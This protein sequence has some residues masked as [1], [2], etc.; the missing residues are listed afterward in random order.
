MRLYLILFL[1]ASGTTALAQT[2][3]SSDYRPKKRKVQELEEVTIKRER[4]RYTTSRTSSSLRM[5]S[6]IQEIPQNIQVVTK[7]MLKDQQVVSMSD[8]LIRNVSGLVR[9][10]HWGD[11]YTNITARGAQVQAFR[12]GFNVVN[13][14]WGPLTED[15]SFVENIEFVKGP[16]GFM[17]S[18]GDP[19][20]LY[21]VVTKKPTG[22]T[23]SEVDLTMGSFGLYRAALDLEGKLS[24]DGNLLYRL[25]VAAQNKKSFRPN[26]YN[27]RYTIAPVVSYQL[28]KKT[29]LTLEYTYQR[30]NMSNVGS[31]YV[32]DPRGFG[33]QPVDYTMLPAGLPG[34]KINDHSMYLNIQHEINDNWK[35]TAQAARFIY[36][37]EGASA[38]PGVVNPDGTVIRN[39]GIWDAKSN[40]TLAQAFVNGDA[41]TGSIHHKI[42]GGL[43]VGSKE[44]FADWSQ[45][46][47]LDDT[48]HYFNIFDPNA[49]VNNVSNGYPEFDRSKSIQERAQL[50]YGFQNQKYTS[51]YVQDELG[52]FNDQLRL[53][54]AGRYTDLQQAYAGPADKAQHFTPRVG[55]SGSV[56]KDLAI[57]AL[58][59]QAFV[60]QS[61]ILTNG[62]KVQPI[63]GNN[64]EVG[65]KKQWMNGRWNTGLTVY[66]ILKNHELTA[67]P[68]QAPSSGLSVELGQKVSEGV[69]FDL[70]GM[71]ARGFTVVANYAY[72]NS[73]VLKVAS[74]IT[75]IEVG[76]VV[77]GFATHTANAWLVYRVQRGPMK[78]FGISGGATLLADRQTYW[79]PTP[80]GG[81]KLAD[82]FKVDAGLSWENEQFSVTANVFNVLNEYLYSGSY[83][84]W[85]N[86]YYW[87]A[88]PP[89]N[90]RLTIGY[91]F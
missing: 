15:M 50:G 57:Y 39:I 52:F 85:L 17:L 76:D 12:N 2:P 56:S 87:Q 35:I 80:A 10:E 34:V 18:S 71:I 83:Y 30:A 41:R 9:M 32:F 49:D 60:P 55:L 63:T 44:Y 37:Q 6:P 73:R 16:A 74:G 91:R 81:A 47:D 24:K 5:M 13:S 22:Q 64:M 65:I 61:G 1:L 19:S 79:D 45:S 3:D 53:T 51:L 67:D 68:S 70:K 43:D 23:K 86:S 8:G 25:N 14:Y 27:D 33:T 54:I 66:R 62:N 38:W 72:T 4:D 48:A 75:D 84:A 7:A 29:K 26:E 31:Y 88:D 58:Y 28:D 69:E 21:N 46:H 78:G 89:R 77:P 20:G 40:M 59:D 90:L 42:L 82:Y 36:N 11:M